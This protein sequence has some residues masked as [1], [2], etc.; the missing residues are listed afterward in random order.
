M[1]T[2]PDRDVFIHHPNIAETLSQAR[3]AEFALV[4]IGIENN[5]MVKL[6]CFSAKEFIKSIND[7]IAGDIGGF[8]FKL[9][10]AANTLMRDRVVGLK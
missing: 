4:G 10:A 5:H 6:G 2:H 9:M 1:S 8:D 7:G 3:K